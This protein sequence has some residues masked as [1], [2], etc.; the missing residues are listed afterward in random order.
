MRL[1]EKSK[2]F[3]GCFSFDVDIISQFEVATELNK[4]EM[5]FFELFIMISKYIDKPCASS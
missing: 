3:A 1:T 2:P 5:A 4:E